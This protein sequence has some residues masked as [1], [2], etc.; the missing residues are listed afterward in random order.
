MPTIHILLERNLPLAGLSSVPGSHRES[1]EEEILI[2]V[3]VFRV[4]TKGI[5]LSAIA[6]VLRILCIILDLEQGAAVRFAT[7]IS[8]A[9][10]FDEKTNPGTIGISDEREVHLK[11]R[12]PSPKVSQTTELEEAMGQKQ[13]CTPERSKSRATPGHK[14]KCRGRGS[15]ARSRR[16]NE[17]NTA[18]I[19]LFQ[20]FSSNPA[21]SIGLML[22]SL[23]STREN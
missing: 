9:L 2:V 3:S 18:R 1:D 20:Y 11:P 7:T 19:L 15:I 8:A 4:V 16:A 14:P 5:E 21:C 6:V 23:A 10:D 17:T 22:K 13:S 12:L